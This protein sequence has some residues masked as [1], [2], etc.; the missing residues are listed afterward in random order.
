MVARPSEALLLV[1]GVLNWGGCEICE[2][3][4]P[5]AMSVGGLLLQGFGFG[6]GEK[7][8]EGPVR[9]ESAVAMDGVR[10]IGEEGVWHG[11]ARVG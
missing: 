5:D 8:W 2:H 4:V 10:E 7:S 9:L 3:L 11:L 6:N 1:V